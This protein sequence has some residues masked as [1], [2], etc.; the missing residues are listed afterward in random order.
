M[1][2][3]TPIAAIIPPNIKE[4]ERAEYLRAP[5]KTAFCSPVVKNAPSPSFF[6]VN[7]NETREY[8]TETENATV[9]KAYSS[10]ACV[11]V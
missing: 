6:N 2:M 5:S 9:R 4:Y 8:S 3:Q 1:A 11:E 7:G 10:S